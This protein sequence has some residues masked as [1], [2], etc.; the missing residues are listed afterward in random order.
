[1]KAFR[2]KELKICLQDAGHMTKIAAMPIYSKKKRFKYLLLQN[3]RAEFHEAWY[4]ASET[5]AHHSF[6][7]DDPGVTLTYF[8]TRSDLVIWAFP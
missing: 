6:L 8:M 5:P 1:M 2:Y 3:R 7:N 4:L